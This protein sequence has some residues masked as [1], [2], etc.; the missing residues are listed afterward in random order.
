MVNMLK[1]DDKSLSEIL[2]NF[3]EERCLAF[4]VSSTTRLLPCYEHY[5][6]NHLS[7][8]SELPRT[9]VNDLWQKALEG[10]FDL[11]GWGDSL[12]QIM[13]MIPQEDEGDGFVDLLAE[14]AL[15][16]LAY[17]IRYL[18]SQDVQ[19]AIWSAKRAYEA[20]DQAAIKMLKAKPESIKFEQVVVGHEFVQRILLFQKKDIEL[21]HAGDIGTVHQNAMAQAIFSR[22]ELQKFNITA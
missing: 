4:S 2:A 15:A 16:S 8:C 5:A 12:E 10:D 22:A 14:D 9:L 7:D 19:E 20:A 21:L 17:S 18:L 11:S 6:R 1:F 13:Q 3:S